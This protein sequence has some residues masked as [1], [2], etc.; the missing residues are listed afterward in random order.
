MKKVST[1]LGQDLY[2]G[3]DE[4]KNYKPWY[5]IVPCGSPAPI[6]GF[7]SPEYIAKEKKIHPKYFFP[8]ENTR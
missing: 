6:T 7:Y 3:K 2:V 1:I 8:N 5:N 4:S